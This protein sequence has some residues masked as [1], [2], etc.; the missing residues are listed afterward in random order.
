MST[1]VYTYLTAVYACHGCA[2]NKYCLHL[3]GHRTRQAKTKQNLL[4]VCLAY[5]LF[6]PEDGAVKS[7]ET[8]SNFYWTAWQHISFG[9]NI[10]SMK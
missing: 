2:Y 7:S 10:I 1:T 8:S 6:N 9:W 3:Q 4:T 5:L